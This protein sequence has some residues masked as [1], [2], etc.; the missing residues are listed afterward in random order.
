[1]IH[2][3]H[4]GYD[5]ATLI[6]DYVQR[7]EPPLDREIID[8]MRKALQV[9]A[10]SGGGY[11]AVPDAVRTRCVEMC[12]ALDAEGDSRLLDILDAAEA[13]AKIGDRETIHD[14]PSLTLDE[15]EEPELGLDP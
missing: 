14:F 10:G 4:E 12:L 3:W 13:R 8:A 15:G 1:P 9:A 2:F 6:H 11:A 7:R 5:K